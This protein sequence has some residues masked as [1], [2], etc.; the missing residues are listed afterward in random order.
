MAGRG[1]ANQTGPWT[2]C[3]NSMTS[4]DQQPGRKS[5]ERAVNVDGLLAEQQVTEA[6]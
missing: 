3:V 4:E 1:K 5:H 2:S 6:T